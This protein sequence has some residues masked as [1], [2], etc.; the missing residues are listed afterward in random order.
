M[1]KSSSLSLTMRPK[2]GKENV[3]SPLSPRSPSSPRLELQESEAVTPIAAYHNAPHSPASPK[4]RKETKSIFANF[5]ATKSSSRILSPGDSIRQIPQKDSPPHSIYANG[6]GSGSTPELSRPMQTPNSED[7]R[8]EFFASEQRANS[9]SVNSNGTS[10]PSNE[11]SSKRGAKLKK[12]GVLSRTKSI[13]VEDHSGNGGKLRANPPKMS[14]ESTATWT[15]GGDEPP[16]R[17]APLEKGQSWRQNIG[18]GKLRTHS[19]DR[20]DSSLHAHREDEAFSRRDRVEQSSLASGSLN[21]KRGVALMS[22][23]GSGARRMGEK[24]ETARKG[25]F[26]KLGRSSSNHDREPQVLKEPYQFKIIHLPLVEQTRMTRISSRLENSKDKT[27]FWMPA[28]PWRCID[29][30]NMRGCEEE[31][32]YRVPGA[33]HTVKFYEQKFDQERDI[34]LIADDNLNDPNVIGSLF[35]NWLRQLPDEIFPKAIQARIQQECQGAKSTPQMLKDEL[36]KLPP[37]N[38]YLLFAIT[39]HISL[40]HS[41]SEYNKMNYN[42]LCICFQPAIKIEA[43]CFQFLILDWRNCWQG[44]WTE[45]EFLAEEI[46]YLEAQENAAVPVRNG[47]GGPPFHTKSKSSQ[48]SSSYLGDNLKA[49]STRSTSTDR[50]KTPAR[51]MSGDRGAGSGRATPP[52][53]TI[54]VSDKSA[55][56]KPGGVADG[57]VSADRGLSSS[58]SRQAFNAGPTPHRGP[59]HVKSASVAEEGDD[60]A[61]PTQAQHTRGASEQQFRL[62][63]SNP[64]SSPF[65][66]KF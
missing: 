58:D 39:C 44:C 4:L 1:P 11:P 41:C 55:N 48:S 54:Y 52:Q 30:L 10:D 43:F 42:N 23:L 7:N 53:P 37:F 60:S 8:S 62:D 64:P 49:S 9:V 6:S 33:A 57:D 61:T 27:E 32:L 3:P 38:Y 36:S 40:L 14:P 2:S 46:K 16:L 63:L 25:M 34:D 35:K 24:M 22:S 13:K 15:S 50:T 56:S 31:G 45:K 20:Q 18:F 17:T 26:G 19:A 29:Y 28:L 47:Q 65:S 5:G 66:V 59:T 12:Q 21:E 51:G